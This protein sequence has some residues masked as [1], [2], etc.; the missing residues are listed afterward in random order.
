MSKYKIERNFSTV[1]AMTIVAGLLS[2]GCTSYA[3]N[4]NEGNITESNTNWNTI[5]GD[6]QDNKLDCR[7]KQRGVLEIDNQPNIEADWLLNNDFGAYVWKQTPMLQSCLYRDG[8]GWEFNAGKA[9]S[10]DKHSGALPWFA[11][12]AVVGAKGFGSVGNMHNK[13]RIF[14]VQVSNIEKLDYS[15]DYTYELKGTSNTHIA[16]WFSEVQKSRFKDDPDSGPW[17]LWRQVPEL[18]VMLKIGG[19]FRDEEQWSRL[20]KTNREWT[21]YSIDTGYGSMPACIQAKEAN[22]T[23]AAPGGQFAT[24]SVW[25]TDGWYNNQTGYHSRDL[26]LKSIITQLKKLGFVKNEWYLMGI[27]FQTEVSYGKGKMKIHSLDY[28]LKTK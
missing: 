27:E 24:S 18:E 21:R 28:D 12:A 4:T 7:D 3:S 19:N 17:A 22:W 5:N 8:T 1:F 25:F 15:V 26:D 11:P 16:L 20:C 9:Y 2:A 13:K 23:T 14:P 6:Y 10:P